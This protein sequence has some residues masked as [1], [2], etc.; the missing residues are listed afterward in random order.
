MLAEAFRRVSRE[1]IFESTGI[2]ILE[3]NTLYQLLSMAK[4]G[5]PLLGA[6][7]TLLTMPDLFNYR[8]CGRQA[9]E[10]T[11]ATTTH[12]S[13]PENGRGPPACSK[14]SASRPAFSRRSS[15][16]ARSWADSFP[17]LPL[18]PECLQSLSLRL[19]ATT[20]VPPSRPCLPTTRIIDPDDASFLQ[21]GLMPGRIR[22]FCAETGQRVPGS[23]GEIARVILQSIALTYRL[24]LR[25][26]EEATGRT[27][28][29][30]HIVGGG[31]K[32]GLL[33]QYTADATGRRCV[34]GPAEATAIGN[35]L[36]QAVGLGRLRSLDEVRAV[37]RRS[38]A[39]QA[40]EPSSHDDRSEAYDRFMAIVSRRK[41][42]T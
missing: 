2:Q 20:P 23:K 24:V 36:M 19:R 18:K 14:V 3:M 8:L 10:F 25:Q 30:V 17:P 1:Q 22:R 41:E 34:A 4:H 32:N 26:L 42:H 9:C 38:F 27:F 31:S 15:S 37:V 21:P 39:V 7:R 35:L 11:I 13:T 33:N 5:S 28:T 12:V 6:A 16:R 29:P 40:Y